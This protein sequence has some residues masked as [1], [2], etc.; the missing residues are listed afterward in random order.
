MIALP[1]SSI[2]AKLYNGLLKGIAIL[3]KNRRGV[4]VAVFIA[5]S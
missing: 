3:Q 4:L 1:K 2:W 5:A